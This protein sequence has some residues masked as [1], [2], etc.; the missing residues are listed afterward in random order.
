MCVRRNCLRFVAI[1][2]ALMG[3]ASVDANPSSVPQVPQPQH[4]RKLR[5]R[6][7]GVF[8]FPKSDWEKRKFNRA[9]IGDFVEYQSGDGE[10]LYRRTVVEVG[11][12]TLVVKETKPGNRKELNSNL[13][14]SFELPDETPGPGNT[15]R[16]SAVTV[17]VQGK[18]MDSRLIEVVYKDKPLEQRWYS[19]DVPLGGLVKH[20]SGGIRVKQILT[21]YGRGK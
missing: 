4:Q 16:E 14:Y 7:A 17:D 15:V 6:I 12:H 18:R 21:D 2:I 3:S 10:T 19:D 8:T 1:S 11:D 13:S 20:V 9:R 5:T